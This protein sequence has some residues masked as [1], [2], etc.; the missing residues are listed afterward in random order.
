EGFVYGYPSS[1]EVDVA[2][3]DQEVILIE[4]TS[5]ARRSDVVLFKRKAAFYERRT[6]RKPSRL[7]IVTPYADDDAIDLSKKLL[8]ELYTKV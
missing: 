8:V 7:I 2:V 1:V 3:H 5:H 6:G 4:V